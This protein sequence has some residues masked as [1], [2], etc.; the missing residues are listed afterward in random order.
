MRWIIDFQEGSTLE[1]YAKQ[2]DFFRIE[3]GVISGNAPIEYAFNLAKPTPDKR[4]G[5]A[6]K[7]ER[8]YFSWQK[9]ALQ[10]TDRQLLTK[11]GINH[12]N[13][14]VVQ[15]YPAD[16]ENLLANV[17]MNYLKSKFPGKDEKLQIKTVRQTRFRVQAEGKSGFTFVVTNQTYLGG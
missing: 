14:L 9:G 15:F 5:P 6:A 8:L 11:A 2:L 12:A 1:A 3:L 16:T 13:K 10:Q 7:E 4:S 17:E